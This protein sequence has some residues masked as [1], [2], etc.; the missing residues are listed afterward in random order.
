MRKRKPPKYEHLSK[1]DLWLVANGWPH[2]VSEKLFALG[3]TDAEEAELAS[4]RRALDSRT[5]IRSATI[6][7]TEYVA[8]RVTYWS[9]AHAR[10]VTRVETVAV[11]LGAVVDDVSEDRAKRRRMARLEAR[12]DH[13]DELWRRRA[14]VLKAKKRNTGK[15]Q[16]VREVE[17]I[18][19]GQGSGLVTAIEWLRRHGQHHANGRAVQ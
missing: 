8:R 13:A 3:I 1:H 15:A 4:T 18:T 16:P 9:H 17:R 14:Q 11:E 10:W 7:Q 12:Q 5:F 19:R 2:L 6:Q